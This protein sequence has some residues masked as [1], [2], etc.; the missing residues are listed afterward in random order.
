MPIDWAAKNFFAF[1]ILQPVSVVW[2]YFKDLERP[3]LEG[4]KL[5]VL[6]PVLLVGWLS[7]LIDE[8]NSQSFATGFIQKLG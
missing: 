7:F 5:T 8:V 2:K 3:K 1:Q 4:I 6:T